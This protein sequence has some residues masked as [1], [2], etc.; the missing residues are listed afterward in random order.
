MARRRTSVVRAVGATAAALGVALAFAPA[1]G[2]DTNGAGPNVGPVHIPTV[3]EQ[4][5]VPDPGQIT[6]PEPTDQIKVPDVP[7]ASGLVDASAG[8]GDIC[9]YW[10][11]NYFDNG[12]Q[13]KT[14]ESDSASDGSWFVLKGTGGT[15]GSSLTGGGDDGQI[16]QEVGETVVPQNFLPGSRVTIRNPW[17]YN[18]VLKVFGSVS[19]VPY[20]GG[21]ASADASFTLN[22]VSGMNGLKSNAVVATGTEHSQPGVPW[23]NEVVDS[24]SHDVNFAIT[25]NVNNVTYY[26][27][28]NLKLEGHTHFSA[29]TNAYAYAVFEGRLNGN[30]LGAFDNGG[31][32]EWDFHLPPNDHIASCG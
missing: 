24:G 10:P 9:Y 19:A 28:I 7:D 12:A 16:E 15:Q 14:G 32:E 30:D 31:V 22:V 20:I 2:A 25:P 18:G 17:A 13:N 23:A 4:I 21:T 27:G 5:T 11:A 6:V 1:A 29:L 26:D 3:S 8:Y